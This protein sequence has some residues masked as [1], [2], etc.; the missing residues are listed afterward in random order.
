MEL[1]ALNQVFSQPAGHQP[2]CS[3][4]VH[5]PA[6]P[7]A[8]AHFSCKDSHTRKLT[9]VAVMKKFHGRR[10]ARPMMKKMIHTAL[11]LVERVEIE[12][13]HKTDFFFF[14]PPLGAH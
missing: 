5:L 14:L 8:L 10:V 13:V 1:R 11:Y 7:W 3:V 9:R 2:G 4:H 12:E 6:A